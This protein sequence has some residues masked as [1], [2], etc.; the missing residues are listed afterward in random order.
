MTFRIQYLLKL[1]G[2]IIQQKQRIPIKNCRATF[3][4]ATC[5]RYQWVVT[6]KEWLMRRTYSQIDMDERRRIAGGERLA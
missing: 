3:R 6:R 5:D 4:S 1:S 2:G